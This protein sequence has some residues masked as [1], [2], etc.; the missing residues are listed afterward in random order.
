MSF[1][2]INGDGAPFAPKTNFHRPSRPPKTDTEKDLMGNLNEAIGKISRLIEVVEEL[3]K[4][5][6]S[7]ACPAACDSPAS[8]QDNCSSASDPE[9][10]DTQCHNDRPSRT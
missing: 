6:T 5:Q 3:I 9:D 4:P 7:E 8:C 2:Y 10:F 1:K